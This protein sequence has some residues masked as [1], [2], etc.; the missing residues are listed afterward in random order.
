MVSVGREFWVLLGGRVKLG[1]T[2]VLG[3]VE[4]VPTA[5]RY[6]SLKVSRDPRCSCDVPRAA[7]LHLP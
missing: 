6:K 7:A 5:R 4:V 1:K 2:F 3:Q